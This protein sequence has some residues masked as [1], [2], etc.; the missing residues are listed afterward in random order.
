M[1]LEEVQEHCKDGHN[2]PLWV[3]EK[4]D[5]SDWV[6]SAILHQCYIGAHDDAYNIDWRCWHDRPTPEI[7][8]QFA[9]EVST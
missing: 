9:W 2:K 8:G 1:T 7:S 4:T 5:Q 6:N 3:E